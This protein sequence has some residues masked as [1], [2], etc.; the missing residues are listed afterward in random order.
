MIAFTTEIIA[1]VSFGFVIAVIPAA[2]VGIIAAIGMSRDRPLSGPESVAIGLAL[3]ACNGYVIG[4]VTVSAFESIGQLL[5][6][7]V[8]SAVVA[9]YTLYAK[10]LG[11]RLLS[12]LPI[13]ASYPLVRS[14]TLSADAI[15]AVD[16]IGQVTIRPS[17]E[18]GTVEGYPPLPPGLRETLAAE[19]WRLPADLPL[20]E[21][22]TVLENSLRASYALSAVSVSID[23]R[24]RA[25]IQAAPASSELASRVPDGWRSVSI[26][27]TV[28]IGMGTNE[29][30]IVHAD[31]EFVRGFVLAVEPTRT[32]SRE[33]M[34]DSGYA[35]HG[36]GTPDRNET[37]SASV[38][39][40]TSDGK[41][42]VTVAVST[43]DVETV[44]RADHRHIIVPSH[45]SDD[46]AAAV[47]HL[48]RSGQLIRKIPVTDLTAALGESDIDRDEIRFLAASR[49]DEQ[50][51]TVA[52]G[53]EWIATPTIDE[54]AD[55]ESVF[56][57]GDTP[58][59]KRLVED[60]SASA[61]LPT[62]IDNSGSVM[63]T[64]GAAG[65]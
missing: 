52:H 33:S 41:A 14:R 51:S 43:V 49:V 54:L 25:S 35:S 24:G 45:D 4:F 28:P 16:A 1:G 64:T 42:R 15:D 62:A 23:G 39:R 47:S 9:V 21:L 3:A 56:I 58:L 65:Q 34:A 37:R 10:R 53:H 26:S 48:E 2:V 55:C 17:G 31:G 61:V 6:V 8:A 57:V 22:E 27:A 59:V 18:I 32:T 63:D 7:G 11:E 40:P 20:S 12:E 29:E 60:D 30:S 5:R 19:S 46:A 44:L 50:A 13:G 38:C 36:T